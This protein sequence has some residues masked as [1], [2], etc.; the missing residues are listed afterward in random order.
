MPTIH[1]YD[2]QTKKKVLLEQFEESNF[3]IVITV[4]TLM[5]LSL[6]DLKVL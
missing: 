2:D 5:Y 4:F 6:S 3:Y 1:N